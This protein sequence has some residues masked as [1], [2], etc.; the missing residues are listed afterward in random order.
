MFHQG[1]TMKLLYGNADEDDDD[2]SSDKVAPKPVTGDV[3]FDSENLK[4]AS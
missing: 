1:P 4:P 2:S 3:A